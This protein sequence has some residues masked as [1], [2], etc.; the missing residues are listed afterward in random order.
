[1]F[2]MAQ[3]QWNILEPIC[4]IIAGS[5]STFWIPLLFPLLG[6][7]VVR[8]NW[9]QSTT[10]LTKPYQ[11]TEGIAWLVIW[12]TYN[13][14]WDGWQLS[15]L[16][17]G[18]QSGYTKNLC[19]KWQYGLLREENLVGWFLRLEPKS[20]AQTDSICDLRGVTLMRPLWLEGMSAM[21]HL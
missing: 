13:C 21:F 9:S 16:D 15:C 6:V 2:N 3:I 10:E 14:N 20:A 4:L 17:W 7:S 19:Y 18:P 11:H 8:T 12:K 5:K 1:M